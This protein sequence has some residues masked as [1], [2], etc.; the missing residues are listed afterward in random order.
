ML[1]SLLTLDRELLLSLSQ[2]VPPEYARLVEIFGESI[3]IFGVLL[4]VGLWLYG[5]YRKDT[6]YK[7][8]ALSIFFTIILIFLVYSIINLGLPQWRL[9]GMELTGAHALIPHPTDNSFPSGHALFSAA[10]LVG[11]WRFLHKWKL[12]VVGLVFALITASCRVLGGVHYPGDIIGGW[13]FGGLSAWL[14]TPL[15]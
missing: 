8:I 10:L 12:F 15:V 7:S 9:G 1:Q 14:V 6:L 3:V 13:I 11:M 5:V 4:L 2:I